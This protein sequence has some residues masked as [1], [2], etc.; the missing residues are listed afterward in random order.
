MVFF[1]P[2]S[3]N[4]YSKLIDCNHF[5]NLID[6]CV[7]HINKFSSIIKGIHGSR[8]CSLEICQVNLICEHVEKY[9]KENVR[10]SKRLVKKELILIFEKYPVGFGDCISLI[11]KIYFLMLPP[12]SDSK[13]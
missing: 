7:E 12:R 2:I 11:K 3:E 9:L 8:S 13:E 4:F 1:N 6:I 5:D 10:S